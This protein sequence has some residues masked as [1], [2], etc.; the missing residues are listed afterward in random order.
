MNEKR[1]AGG[2]RQGSSP[3]HNYGFKGIDNYALSQFKPFVAG[4]C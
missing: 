4:W 1:A 3:S 2:R